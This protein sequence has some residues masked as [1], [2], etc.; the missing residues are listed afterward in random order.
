M[1]TMALEINATAK[2]ILIEIVHHLY[3]NETWQSV[4]REMQAILKEAVALGGLSKMLD[5]QQWISLAKRY[6]HENQPSLLS[7]CIAFSRLDSKIWI[8]L[9]HSLDDNQC[10]LIYM[11]FA[12]DPTTLLKEA[13]HHFTA[14]RTKLSWECLLA[15]A[16]AGITSSNMLAMAMEQ[17]KNNNIALGLQVA[18]ATNL[19][20]ADWLALVSHIP[21]TS[22]NGPA[23]QIWRLSFLHCLERSEEKQR[24]QVV[25]P[26]FNT[27]QA[28]I[29]L[30][31]L[32][33]LAPPPDIMLSL[34]IN[35]LRE[36]NIES[37]KALLPYSI[38]VENEMPSDGLKCLAIHM[39]RT[40]AEMSPL[41]LPEDFYICLLYTSPSPRDRTRSRMPSSA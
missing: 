9:V 7:E 38:P 22:D 11:T 21:Q 28:D 40:L 20:L 8:S 31:T 26:A 24:H 10:K 33:F 16:N 19:N 2:H 27:K 34:F 25:Y 6:I 23:L 4:A 37:A 12:L 13:Q 5:N 3:P 32:V 29:A 14:K 18:C 35:C 36:D 1:A 15:A 39:H 41:M 30:E 17:I